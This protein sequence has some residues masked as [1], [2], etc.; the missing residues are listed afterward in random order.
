MACPLYQGSTSGNSLKVCGPENWIGHA[1]SYGHVKIFC[2]SISA[3]ENCPSYK[4]K[5]VNGT[6]SHSWFRLIKRAL[7]LFRK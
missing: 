5:T 2:L 6:R 3:Y 1:P 4:R 7:G